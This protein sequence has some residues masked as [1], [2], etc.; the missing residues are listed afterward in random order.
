VIQVLSIPRRATDWS[1]PDMDMGAEAATGVAVVAIVAR[2]GD[3]SSEKNGTVF[4]TA[5][6]FVLARGACE[7]IF[8]EL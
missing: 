6:N 4:L 7:H 3:A 1:T 5:S 8:L 2:C